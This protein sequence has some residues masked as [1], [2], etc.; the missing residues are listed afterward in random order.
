MSRSIKIQL[1]LANGAPYVPNTHSE[2]RHVRSIPKSLT[3]V[4]NRGLNSEG[5]IANYL[6]QEFIGTYAHAYVVDG[7]FP[8]LKQ[9]SLVIILYL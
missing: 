7:Y 4:S 8:S 1:L 5:S 2:V 9:S 6:S 3:K